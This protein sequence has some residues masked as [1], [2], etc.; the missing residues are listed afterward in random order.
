MTAVTRYQKIQKLGEGTYGV[1][2][3]ARDLHTGNIVALK[4]I[5]LELEDE[6]VPSTSVREISVLK[7]LQHANIV[8]LLDV[9]FTSDKLQ[10]VFEFLDQ[11]LKKYIDS[12]TTVQPDLVQSYMYQIILGLDFCHSRRIL[13]RD[14]KP[15]NLLIDREGTLKIADLGLA[16]A[17]T[18]PLRP[19]THEVVT[20]WYRAPEVLLGSKTYGIGLDMWSVGCIFAEMLNNRPLFPGDSEIDEL[21]HI[22]RAL[23][24]PN[25]ET[26]PGVSRL[27]YY[28]ETFPTW[29]AKPIQQLL[30]NCN[31]PTAVDL[32]RQMLHYE[33]TRRIS[34][35]QALNHPYFRTIDRSNYSS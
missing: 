21:F 29:K 8:R 11:D 2:Y 18:I 17:V 12:V 13:H 19:Y 5:R 28:S 23:G 30:P 10:L 7:E 6:G 25:E 1:V 34:C 31:D 3:Q 14:L 32:L 15:Q 16:R 27:Q 4:K 33:P 9:V 20:L 24:T 26:W 22:F 35:K